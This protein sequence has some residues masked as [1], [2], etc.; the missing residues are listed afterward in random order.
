M[1]LGLLDMNQLLRMRKYQGYKH[2]KNLRYSQSNVGNVHQ[3]LW[4]ALKC[5]WNE[6]FDRGFI[7][8]MRFNACG[9]FK[10]P[11]S[12]AQLV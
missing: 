11:D 12:I 8:L 9:Q 10:E 6:N 5:A 1:K 4:I 7:Y 3:I 2:R